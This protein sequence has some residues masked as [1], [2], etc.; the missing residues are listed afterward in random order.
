MVFGLERFTVMPFDVY[1]CSQ[2]YFCPI[3]AL[4]RQGPFTGRGKDLF[5][6]RKSTTSRAPS[7]HVDDFLKQQVRTECVSLHSIANY[8]LYDFMVCRV[9]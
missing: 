1:S 6:S 3:A 8:Y 2:C 5:R 9:D 7:M 4:L